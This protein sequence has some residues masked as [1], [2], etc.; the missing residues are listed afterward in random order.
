MLMIESI[1]IFSYIGNIVNFYV[2]SLSAC[3]LSL[4]IVIKYILLYKY[5][6]V[7]HLLL[8]YVFYNV[9]KK[10]VS[11]HILCNGIM[12]TTSLHTL[13]CVNSLA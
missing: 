5:I 3:F 12:G 10:Q 13:M 11:K 8:H 1:F 7:F 6:S 4:L 2:Y 9:S